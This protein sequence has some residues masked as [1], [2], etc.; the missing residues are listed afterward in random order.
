MPK[1]PKNPNWKKQKTHRG[2]AETRRRT[3]KNLPQTNADKRRSEEIARNAKIAKESKLK[4]AKDS[5][6]RRGD[7]E[8]NQ[9]E[10]AA[11][12]RR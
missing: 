8:E 4:K 6:R 11:D 12:Q 3:K 1:L 5:P 10:F 7:A 9:K 2:G